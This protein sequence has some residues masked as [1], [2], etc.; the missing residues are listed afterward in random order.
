[1][2]RQTT[3]LDIPL[4]PLRTVLFPGMTLPLHIFEERYKRMIGLCL[5]QRRS[6]GVV[7]IKSGPEVGG[8]AVP[9]DVGTVARIINAVPMADGCFNIITQGAARFQ[10][11]ESRHQAGYLTAR[12]ELLEEEEVDARQL[13]EQQAEVQQRFEQLVEELSKLTERALEPFD[14]PPGP[15]ATSYF[16]AANLPVDAWEKQRLL[17]AT[18]TDLRLTVERRIL[19]RERDMLRRFATARPPYAPDE[20]EDNPPRLSPN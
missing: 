1:M 12:V 10:V 13:A 17:E 6:F 9:Y 4:F 19:R 16:V 20:D 7:L 8:E 11:L 14:F 5:E 3:T 15:T 2:D 18:S